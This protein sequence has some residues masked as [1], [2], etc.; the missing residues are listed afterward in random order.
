MLQKWYPLC[1]NP[2]N[3]GCLS[4]LKPQYQALTATVENSD[5]IGVTEAHVEDEAV[6]GEDGA[7][8]SGAQDHL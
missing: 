8:T 3:L 6:A 4:P 1:L 5:F 2:D 7:G